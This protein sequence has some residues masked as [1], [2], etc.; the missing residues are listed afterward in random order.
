MVEMTTHQQVADFYI[1]DKDMRD[2]FVR[3]MH[4]RWPHSE[5]GHVKHGYSKEW[6][7]RFKNGIAYSSSDNIGQALLDK[8]GYKD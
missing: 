4:E 8:W 3:Y 7:F 2:V 1:L 6:A 5:F